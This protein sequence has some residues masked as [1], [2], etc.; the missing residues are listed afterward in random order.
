MSENINIWNPSVDTTFGPTDTL[1]CIGPKP[2]N[3]PDIVNKA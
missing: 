1:T 2:K 3:N